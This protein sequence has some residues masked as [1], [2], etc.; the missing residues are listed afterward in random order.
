[1]EYFE[2]HGDIKTMIAG[3]DYAKYHG[4]IKTMIAGGGACQV[5]W[6]YKD[7]DSTDGVC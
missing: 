3:V 5:S 1:M 6:R 7:Y 2:Y 4:D